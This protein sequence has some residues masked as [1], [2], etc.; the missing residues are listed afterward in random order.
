MNQTRIPRRRCAQPA[1]YQHPGNVSR[2]KEDYADCIT[3]EGIAETGVKRNR[4]GHGSNKISDTFHRSTCRCGLIAS[5]EVLVNV[6]RLY[7]NVSTNSGPTDNDSHRRLL[8]A[9]RILDFSPGRI[10]FPLL[11][12]PLATHRWVPRG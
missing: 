6:A 3:F 8:S 4:K 11:S 2:R 10:L 9:K 1:H 5:L 12:A 7:A